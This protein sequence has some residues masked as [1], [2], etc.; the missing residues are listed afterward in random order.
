MH[1][2]VPCRP[3]PRPSDLAL[4][5]DSPTAH[6]GAKETG[7][8]RPGSEGAMKFTHAPE[9]DIDIERLP[10]QCRQP[11]TVHHC[12]G[13]RF[14]CAA[15]SP[16]SCLSPCS[17]PAWHA[18]LKNS[19]ACWIYTEKDLASDT[20]GRGVTPQART[21]RRR[22]QHSLP[23]SWPRGRSL[24]PGSGPQS[25]GPRGSRGYTAP[26]RLPLDPVPRG[27]VIAS[28]THD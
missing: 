19:S 1:A 4:P 10:R 28:T 2:L 24:S 17:R 12:P 13:V 6:T 15:T 22:A 8:P 5:G 11:S 21:R 27:S 16:R 20:N 23:K 3:A 14:G 9:Q 25:S 7:R 18:A 26:G